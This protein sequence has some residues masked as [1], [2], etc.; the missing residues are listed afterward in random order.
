MVRRNYRSL[1]TLGIGLTF[2]V[3]KVNQQHFTVKPEKSG[4]KFLPVIVLWATALI[5][6]ITIWGTVGEG[7]TEFKNF[8][9]L[10][11]VLMTLLV[12]AAPL[13]YLLYKK[14]FSIYHP[15][16]F[17]AL[18]YFIPAFVVGGFLLAVGVSEPFYMT[19]IKDPEYYFPLSYFIVMLGFAGLSAGF[20]LPVGGF[21]GEK[22]KNALPTPNWKNENLYFPGLVLLGLGIFTTTFA[23]IVGV[24][25]YQAAE[26]FGAYDGVIFLTT[27]FW[28][29][30]SFMLWLLLFKRGKFDT[31][32]FAIGTIVLL[33]SFTKALYAGN[34]GNLLQVGVLMTLAYVLAGNKIKLKQ[35]FIITGLLFVAIT[36]GMIYGTT[37]RNVKQT[38][39]RISIDQ[40]TEKIFETFDTIGRKDNMKVL[41]SGFLSL[42]DRLF[43]TGT[44]LAVVVSNY[45]ELKPY[46]EGYGLDNN[47][48]KDTVTTFIP[49]VFW[50]DKPLASDPRRYS[51]LYFNFGESS[52][53]I[54]PMGDLIRN[55]GIV[56]VFLGMVLLGVI[57]RFI[58][59][60]LIYNQEFSVWRTVLFFMLL[61]TVSYEGFY[62]TIIPLLIKF[63]VISIVG[64]LIIHILVKKSND[65]VFPAHRQI[66]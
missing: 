27:L 2:I 50:E 22:M 53:A 16:V 32:A 41:E 12:I 33:I 51:E 11:W 7:F 3:Q 62:G 13:A 60:S 18:T 26:S 59:E 20:F 19:Y 39:S 44:S 47:I 28:M 15:L 46:E 49:R 5:T 64:L 42:S 29:Q 56:G 14:Q 30:A 23:Y 31:L 45:E 66:V 61:T 21:L 1:Q 63:A 34:R 6:G 55:F 17:A 58:Y 35:G 4:R 38:E 57:L 65:P 9:I 48:L 52:F 43:E 10:P 40:Y 8:Y 24:L 37:F 54:T 36:V 25:G